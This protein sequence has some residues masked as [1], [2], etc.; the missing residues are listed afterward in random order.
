[1]THP[2]YRLRGIGRLL[3]QKAEGRARHDGR[4]L[5]VLDTREGD[6]SNILYTS[7]EYI[8]AGRIPGYARSADG[9][10]DATVFYYKTLI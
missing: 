7:L 6:P 10:L 8:E 3:M 1:M 2:N 5:L 9:N 4:T